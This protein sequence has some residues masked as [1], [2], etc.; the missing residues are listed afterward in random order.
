MFHSEVSLDEVCGDLIDSDPALKCHSRS[1]I[2]VRIVPGMDRLALLLC[3][4]WKGLIRSAVP[5][6]LTFSFVGQGRT[7]DRKRACGG[8]LDSGQFADK[9][10]STG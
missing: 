4:L 8:L 6:L 7:R 2:L 1:T 3:A 9:A 10:L 5:S